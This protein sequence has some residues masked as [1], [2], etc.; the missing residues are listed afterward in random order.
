MP[1]SSTSLIR[2]MDLSVG[3]PPGGG[4]DRSSDMDFW[5][6]DDTIGSSGGWVRYVEAWYAVPPEMKQ[7]LI[8]NYN[9][10]GRSHFMTEGGN[11]PSTNNPVPYTPMV[12]TAFGTMTIDQWADDYGGFHPFRANARESVL[13]RHKFNARIGYHGNVTDEKVTIRSEIES[14]EEMTDGGAVYLPNHWFVDTTA[15]GKGRLG[16]VD[17]DVPVADVAD[18]APVAALVQHL[19]AN[20]Y[21]AQGQAISGGTLAADWGVGDGDG[22]T[23]TNASV[24]Q[25]TIDVQ[26]FAIIFT[27]IRVDTVGSGNVRNI[28][29][30]FDFDSLT[31]TQERLEAALDATITLGDDIEVMHE[32]G[33]RGRRAVIGGAEFAVRRGQLSIDHVPVGNSKIG[34]LSSAGQ[35][36]TSAFTHWF[37]E[38]TSNIAVHIPRPREYVGRSGQERPLLI[39][40]HGPGTV[41]ILF[42]TENVVTLSAGESADLRLLWSGLGREFL[43]GRVPIRTMSATR[44]D[45]GNIWQGGYFDYS[46]SEFA[47]PIRMPA[48]QSVDADAFTVPATDTLAQEEEFT[49]ANLGRRRDTFTVEKPGELVF[50]KN[51]SWAASAGGSMPAGAKTVLHIVR[52]NVIIPVVLNTYGQFNNATPYELTWLWIG[53]VEEDDLI[54]PLLVYP[55]STTMNIGLATVNQAFH[56]ARL[57]QTI[58]YEWTEA[59]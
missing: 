42:Q 56:V 7:A 30:F 34:R 54:D 39:D 18:Y 27:S 59:A 35:T 21:V 32:R 16:L 43:R 6:F 37:H 26:T 3:Y 17:I 2:D 23:S 15:S 20:R 49:A 9:L 38:G 13:K 52:N 28:W 36:V 24:F 5:W 12:R 55:S 57:E 1:F 19:N 11:P 10:N 50:Y 33:L 51:V 45:G 31:G 4:I 25:F 41:E 22:A 44:G 40:N 53:Q 29:L 46:E 14:E 8:D 58:D 47:M 48:P